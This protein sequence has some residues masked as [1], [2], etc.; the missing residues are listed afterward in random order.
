MPF[1]CF[2][3][4]YQDHAVCKRCKKY[5]ALLYN[6][7]TIL[8]RLTLP[9]SCWKTYTGIKSSTCFDLQRQ[10]HAGCSPFSYRILF[11]RD[12]PS[13]YDHYRDGGASHDL[14]RVRRHGSTVHLFC[15]G[16]GFVSRYETSVSLW[17]EEITRYKK[18]VGPTFARPTLPHKK[19]KHTSW[20]C[21]LNTLLS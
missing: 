6:N 19:N 21:C 16:A 10:G 1:R 17:D 7:T 20:L 3:L 11:F 4:Q 13:L 9:R 14:G 5:S 15:A 8:D 18:R 2:D 12:P